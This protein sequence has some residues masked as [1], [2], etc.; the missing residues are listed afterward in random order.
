MIETSITL[1]ND[2]LDISANKV[3]YIEYRMKNTGTVALSLG[4]RLD[5]FCKVT[6]E[7]GASLPL[8]YDVKTGE[9]LDY[10]MESSK[11]SD[12][13]LRTIPI[14]SVNGDNY[15]PSL[16]QASNGNLIARNTSSRNTIADIEERYN[17]SNGGYLYLKSFR[18]YCV[19]SGG[20]VEVSECYA[21][22][23]TEYT[24]RY[25][26]FDFTMQEG[27][28]V[29]LGTPTGLRFTATVDSNDWD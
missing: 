24:E 18:V 10:E 26:E 17:S 12:S 29:R 21:M 1:N 4:T 13:T 28:S 5:I 15:V 8:V 14:T 6:R 2:S 20:T 25:N 11:R 16:P 7:D 19:Q 27:A 22:S 23:M 3:A 9:K